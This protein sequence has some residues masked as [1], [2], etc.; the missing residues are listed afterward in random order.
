MPFMR[1]RPYWLPVALLLLAAALVLAMIRDWRNLQDG[2]ACDLRKRIVGA[3]YQA[4]GL[5]PYF[6]KWQPGQ[7]EQWANPYEVGPGLRQNAV[8]LPPSYLWVLQ[9]LAKLSF[10]TVEKVWWVLQYLSLAVMALLM[11]RCAVGTTQRLWV[12]G[13]TG[14]TLF[15]AGWIVNADIG[16]SYLLFPLIWGAGYALGRQKR[17]FQWAGIALALVCWLRP[18][19]CLMVLPFL[20]VPQR[21]LFL[22]GLVPTALVLGVQLLI[23]GQWQNWVDFF[24]SSTLWGKYYASGGAALYSE[25]GNVALPTVI[26]GQ[27]DFSITPL[28][29]YLANLPLVLQNLIDRPTTGALVYGLLLMLGMAFLLWMVWKRK[30]VLRIEQLWLA[31]FL[32]YYLLEI[33]AVLPKPSYYWVEMLFP[34]YLLACN[35]ASVR[36]GTLALLAVGLL[37]GTLPTGLLPMHLLLG[38]YLVALALLLHWLMGKL[39]NQ[40]II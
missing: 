16:Q 3:R 17:P 30:Q 27:T 18:V 37:L 19:C 38:E 33:M 11:G 21:R 24:Q 40:E 14:A 35:A 8:T 13:I 26:E 9:P 29:D 5:S 32:L 1:Y 6:H 23:T 31:G 7:S 39:H 10:P 15:S 36:R 25:V 12:V 22:R 34:V 20:L 28:P 4:A 2:Y